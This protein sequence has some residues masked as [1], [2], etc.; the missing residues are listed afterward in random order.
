MLSRFRH[1]PLASKCQR[2]SGGRRQRPGRRATHLEICFNFWLPQV[3]QS[4]HRGLQHLQKANLRCGWKTPKFKKREQ[5]KPER[6]GE[7]DQ[8][9]WSWLWDPGGDGDGRDHSGDRHD[10][11]HGR[12]PALW[13]R[14]PP[15]GPRA[16]IQGNL[17][18]DRQR[19][20]SDWA[21]YE[22]NALPEG[23]RP[24]EPTSKPSS[25]RPEQRRTWCFSATRSPPAPWSPTGTCLPWT[26]RRT[27]SNRKS[28]SQSDGCVVVQ[29]TTLHIRLLPFRSASA[30]GCALGGGSQNS[31]S[32]CSPS[33]SCRGTGSSTIM[34][35]S[36]G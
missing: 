4:L 34:I 21:C 33:R 7:D 15:W 36:A 28:S 26:T 14:H 29:V 6:A 19:Q 18:S 1:R 11:Q 24:Q 32:T 27:S 25:A 13:P 22:A 8:E 5:R 30:R 16:T 23:L 35:R 9:S 17:R 20:G 3:W 10:R 2:C 31:R 12:L